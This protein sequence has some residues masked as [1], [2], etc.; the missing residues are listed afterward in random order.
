MPQKPFDPFEFPYHIVAECASLWTRRGRQPFGG[1]GQGG[2]SH[3][4][5]EPVEQMIGLR[6]EVELEIP[7]RLAPIGEKLDLL[8]HLQALGLKKVEEAALG[9][10]VIRLYKGKTFTRG[11]SVFVVPSEREDTLAGNHL[12]PAL[13]TALG[14]DIAAIN[15]DRQRPIGDRQRTPVAWTPFDKG[16]VLVT[17]SVLD[18][19][20]QR[21][22]VVANGDG[23][24]GFV[25]R[26]HVL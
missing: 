11:R 9:L 16:A 18:A 12:E 20:R 24:Q 7:D 23:L 4:N 22:D 3:R 15:T 14:F 10:L 8:V 26:Q 2:Q 5:M 25:E 1:L 21:E 19:F 13:R 6:A 17:Q